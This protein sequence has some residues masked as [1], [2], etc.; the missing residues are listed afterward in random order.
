MAQYQSQLLSMVP[1]AIRAYDEALG[2]DDLRLAFAAAT[3]LM[4]SMRVLNNGFVERPAEQ[5]DPR[6]QKVQF[7]GHMLEMMLE[8]KRQFD[9]PLPHE[10]HRLAEEVK[11]EPLVSSL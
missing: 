7:L 10:L 9:V 8:K 5:P 3:K 6:Q 1:K 4:E 2:S 11:D